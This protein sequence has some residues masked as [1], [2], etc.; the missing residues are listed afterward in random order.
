MMLTLVSPDFKVI[1]EKEKGGGVVTVQR[2]DFTR[3]SLI[4]VFGLFQIM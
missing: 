2:A 4:A 1:S 3:K